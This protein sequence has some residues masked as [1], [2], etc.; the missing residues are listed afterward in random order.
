MENFDHINPEGSSLRKHQKAMLEMLR[1]V[2]GICEKHNIPYFLSGGTLLGAV[3]HKGFIP[4]DDDLDIIFLKKDF[5][6][7]IGILSSS[8]KYDLQTYQQDPFYVAP[9]AKLRMKNTEIVECNSNDKF[10]AYKGI[11]IDL[12]YLEPA[13]PFL[14][15]VANCLQNKLVSVSLMDPKRLGKRIYVSFLHT[16]IYSIFFPLFNFLSFLF[17][18]KY[19]SY[20]L[21]S[22]FKTQFLKKWYV[23]SLKMEFEKEQF[24]VP[25]YYDEVLKAQYDD[26]HRIPSMNEIQNHVKSVIFDI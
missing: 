10:Y 20:P 2:S 23:S 11:Y 7:L 15:R 12:F 17:S 19:I 22:F 9:Y 26:Y 25:V 24:N 3:R 14:H 8:D 5:K 18:R 13:I 21:G 4:W 6:K 16:V 1:Y